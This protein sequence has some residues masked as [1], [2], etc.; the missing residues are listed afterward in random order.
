MTKGMTTL[1]LAMLADEKK[2]RWDQPVTELYPAFKL[3][4]ANTTKHVLMEHLICACTGLP[5]QDFE[6]IFEF[7]NATAASSLALL[8]TMQPTDPGM[9]TQMGEHLAAEGYLVPSVREPVGAA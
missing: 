1:L 4:D 2:L 7:Q 8:G 9:Y 6:W 5:R 3:G